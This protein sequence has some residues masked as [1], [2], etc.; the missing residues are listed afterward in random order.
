MAV[1]YPR[2]SRAAWDRIVVHGTEG[3]GCAVAWAAAT[4]PRLWTAFMFDPLGFPRS[5][6]QLRLRW[7]GGHLRRVVPVMGTRRRL[8]RSIVACCDSGVGYEVYDASVARDLVV[9]RNVVKGPV[10]S[11]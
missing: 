6:Q 1:N 8:R 5:V 11:N 2:M 9:G 3:R 4:T 7:S 10:G